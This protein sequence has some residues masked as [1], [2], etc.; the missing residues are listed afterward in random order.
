MYTWIGIF[1]AVFGFVGL[2]LIGASIRAFF[3][4]REVLPRARSLKGQVVEIRERRQDRGTSYYPVVEVMDPAGRKIRFLSEDGGSKHQVKVKPGDRVDVIYDPAEDRYEL[5]AFERSFRPT[6]LF[7]VTGILFLVFASG[8]FCLVFVLGSGP[9]LERLVEAIDAGDENLVRHILEKNPG[10]VDKAYCYP[11][12]TGG[13]S[14]KSTCEYPL[15]IAAERP[16]SAGMVKLLIDYGAGVHKKNN[17]GKTALHGAVYL[18]RLDKIE[19]LLESGA[20]INAS[21]DNGVTPMHII[22]GNKHNYSANPKWYRY[23]VRELLKFFV[24]HGADLNMKTKSGETPLHWA[25]ENNRCEQALTLCA[26]GA[27]IEAT[28]NDGLMPIDIAMKN[29]NKEMVQLLGMEGKCRKLIEYRQNNNSMPD[30]VLEIAVHETMCE[31]GKAAACIKAGRMHQKA[32][33]IPL[34]DQLAVKYFRLGCENDDQRGC[35]L[36]GLMIRDGKGGPKNENRSVELFRQACDRGFAAA[37]T[38]LGVAY[39]KAIGVKQDYKFARLFYEKGCKGKSYYGC[40]N[41]GRLLWFG[42]GGPADKIQAKKFFTE[43]CN[44]EVESACTSLKKLYP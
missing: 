24:A 34:N 4:H 25:A 44:G 14:T 27:N 21:D 12:P 32:E 36:L 29:H 38:N 5:E 26:L 1:L 33:G 37:C 28:N 23:S 41:L 39:E 40:N 6:L 42:H 19:I 17:T 16:K 11:V 31:L 13:T 43:A 30:P 22:C 7:L 9:H 15:Y 10:V 20:D 18:A 3:R 35:N 2:F 8:F